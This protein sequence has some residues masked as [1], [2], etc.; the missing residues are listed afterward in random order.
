MVTYYAG[1]NMRK[2]TSFFD[3][4]DWYNFHQK[5]DIYMWEEEARE[6]NYILIDMAFGC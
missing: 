6:D 4:D 5:W 2:K 1:V 3:M